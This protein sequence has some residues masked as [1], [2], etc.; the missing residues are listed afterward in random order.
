MHWPKKFMP[1]RE[2]SEYPRPEGRAS[3]TGQEMKVILATHGGLAAAINYRLP[4]RVVDTDTLTEPAAAELAQLVADATAAKAPADARSERARD[5]MS[6]TI[7]VEDGDHQVVLAESD[8]SMSPEFG[9]LLS[10]LEQRSA[11]A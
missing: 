4:P 11:G 2:E 3:G 10:W 6:Y 1:S 7:T 8:T 9:A 5:E